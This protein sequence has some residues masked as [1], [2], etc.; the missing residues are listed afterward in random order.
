MRILVVGAGVAGLTTAYALHQAHETKLDIRVVPPHT[1][2]L[3][4][5]PKTHAK[6]PKKT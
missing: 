5:P 4:S 2:R 1:L 6:V 3:P